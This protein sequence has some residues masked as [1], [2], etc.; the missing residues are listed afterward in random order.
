MKLHEWMTLT[1]TTEDQLAE[2]TGISQASINRYRRGPRIPMREAQDKIARATQGAVTRDDWPKP[3]RR[4]GRGGVDWT[5]EMRARLIAG[6]Q[7][8]ESLRSMAMA[9]GV[10]QNALTVGFYQIAR[11]IL[12]KDARNTTPSR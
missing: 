6:I 2:M 1:R 8:D 3:P 12:M 5:K 7:R 11:E 10:N 9:I 4:R